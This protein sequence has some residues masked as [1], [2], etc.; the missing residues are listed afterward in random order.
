MFL[1]TTPVTYAIDAYFLGLSRTTTYAID[2]IFG[3]IVYYGI[4]ATGELKKMKATNE[5]KK[6]S[7]TCVLVK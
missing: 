2:V 4:K 7:A 5:L 3:G 1:S 6:I